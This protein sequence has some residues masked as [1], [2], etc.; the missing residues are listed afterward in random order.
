MN[1]HRRCCCGVRCAGDRRSGCHA[2]RA[3]REQ[4][5]REPRLL[6]PVRGHARRA[7][8]RGL[9]RQPGSV[10]QRPDQA[11]RARA[12][13][14]D[15]ARSDPTSVSAARSVTSVSRSRHARRSTAGANSRE[16][17]NVPCSVRSTT[18]HRSVTGP[19]SS[20][21][22]ATTSRSR[23]AKRSRS[24]SIRR[25]SA[26]SIRDRASRGTRCALRSRPRRCAG[27]R[28]SPARCGTPP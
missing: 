13:P 2:H 26:T 27:A 1:N 21:P 12:D 10:D 7:P 8:T 14:D 9:R 22:T 17:R 24:P 3:P 16:Q 18:D 19:T 28:C 23:S 5:R 25:V 4:P 20:T 6:L 11:L 15:R